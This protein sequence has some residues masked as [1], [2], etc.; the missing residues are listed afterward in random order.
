MN[1]FAFK[2]SSLSVVLLAMV[3]LA[4]E[5]SQ[6]QTFS[7]QPPNILFISIDDLNDWSEP[8]AGNTQAITPNLSKF[9]EEALNFTQNY[10]VSPG[11]NPSRTSTMTGLYPF[12]SGMYSNYQD[13]RKV[14]KSTETVHLAEYFKANGYFT[15]GAGKIYHYNQVHPDSWDDYYPSQSQNMPQD[16]MPEVRPASMPAFKYMYGMFDWAKMEEDDSLMG[17][18]RSVEYISSQLEREQEKPF[19][20]ATG[21]YRPHLPWYVPKKYFDLFPLDSIK[22]PAH[23]ADDTTDLGERAKELIARGGNYHKHVLAADKWKEAVQA[24]LASI[25]AADAMVGLLLDNLAKSKYADNTIVVIWSDHGWQ[26]GEKMHWRKFALWENTIRTLL[27]IKVPKGLADELPKAA[28]SYTTNLTSLIDIYPTLIDLT[29][30]PVNKNLEGMSLVPILRNP[31]TVITRSILTSYDFADYSVRK[32]NWHYI[33][34]VDDSEELYDLSK[35]PEE[36]HNLVGNDIYDDI[37]AEL[38]ME[39]PLTTTPLIDSTLIPLME[40]HV[41]PVTSREYYFSNERRTWLKRFEN[42]D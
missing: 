19:F 33:Q 17:D 27:M 6:E 20:L 37:I 1:L 31:D 30:L 8:L 35:D 18:Y 11:C 24:Y 41:P 39:I 10:C 16:V 7:E 36:W 2:N 3:S 15:A 26:L 40:H 38:R 32:D 22:L 4:C 12:S 42:I 13:W 25:A 14:K 5:T 28:G 21:I 34:Y 29:G 9:G 23:Y